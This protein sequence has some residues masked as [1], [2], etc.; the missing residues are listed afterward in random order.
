MFTAPSHSPAVSHLLSR[1]A[2]H[3]ER[4]RLSPAA[5]FNVYQEIIQ[6]GPLVI[7]PLSDP[8]PLKH[9]PG[10]HEC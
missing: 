8:A 6:L 3:V 7:L 2:L 4:A 5:V 1:K 9:D 10:I